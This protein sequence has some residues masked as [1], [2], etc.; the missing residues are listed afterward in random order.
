MSDQTP[1]MLSQDELAEILTSFRRELAKFLGDR[2]KSL[3][4]YGSQAHGDA[5]PDSDVDVFIELSEL[6]P[7]LRRRISEIA[8]EVGFENGIVISTF[9][10]TTQSMTNGPMA[11]NP[12]LKTIRSEGIVI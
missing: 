10:A 12:I 8:W 11:A 3:Y 5:H 2:L 9:A 6:T 7:D 4:L 1:T